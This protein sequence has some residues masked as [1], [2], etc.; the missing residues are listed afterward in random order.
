MAEPVPARYNTAALWHIEPDETGRPS[1]DLPIVSGPRENQT[2][3][4]ETAEDLPSATRT[5]PVDT[6]EELPFG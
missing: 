3:G 4:D 2:A 5:F 1:E 6:D